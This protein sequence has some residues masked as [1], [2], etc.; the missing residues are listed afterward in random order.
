MQKLIDSVIKELEQGKFSEAIIYCDKLILNYPNNYIFFEIKGN[1]LLETGRTSEAIENY[2]N[3]IK[4]IIPTD[5]KSKSDL[6]ALYNRRGFAKIKENDLLEAV[7]DFKQSLSYNPDFAEAYNNKGN[8]YRKLEKYEKAI[9]QCTKAIEIKPD[10]AEAFNNRG[11][12]YYLLSKDA[13]AINDY[14]K[15]IEL[16]HN[17]AGAY[18]NRGTAYYY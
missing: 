18:Y 5:Q 6:A 12:N 4:F 14:T 15:A 8:V 13:E 10:F 16:K 3:A 11:N 9:K 2:S 17:Y 7:N 1:C